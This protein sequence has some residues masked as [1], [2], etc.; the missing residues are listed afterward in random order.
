MSLIARFRQ[1]KGQ[2]QVTMELLYAALFLLVSVATGE[3]VDG[4]SN[5]FSNTSYVYCIH[6][7][8]SISF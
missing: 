7:T 8:V 1:G 5:T 4:K 3:I 2:Y 6:F